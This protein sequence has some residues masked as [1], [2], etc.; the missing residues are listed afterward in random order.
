MLNNPFKEISPTGFRVQDARKKKI[1]GTFIEKLDYF[2]EVLDPLGAALKVR[3]LRFDITEFLISTDYPHIEL[4][5]PSRSVQTILNRLAEFLNFEITYEL[6]SFDL[7]SLLTELITVFPKITISRVRYDGVPVGQDAFA[8]IIISGQKDARE[9]IPSFLK[10]KARKLRKFTVI[11]KEPR[12]RCEFSD[13]GRIF[14]DGT[15]SDELLK[16]LRACFVRLNAEA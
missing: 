11:S 10:G 3:R 2:D 8:T 4:L 9:S 1:S 6:V 7:E 14:L 15:D 12:F 16:A 13:S 5:N